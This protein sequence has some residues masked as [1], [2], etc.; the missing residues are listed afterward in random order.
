MSE[1]RFI[2]LFSIVG[3]ISPHSQVTVHDLATEYEVS[4]RTIKRDVQILQDAKLGVFCE[5]N[6]IK[7]SR[8]GYKRIRSWMLSD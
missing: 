7:I 3:Q 6:K 5:E 1:Q 2:R 8:T 4:E